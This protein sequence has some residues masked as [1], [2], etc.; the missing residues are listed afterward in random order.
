MLCVQV[1]N[2]TGVSTL[3]LDT[4]STPS[5]CAYEVLTPAEIDNLSTVSVTDFATLYQ[6]YFGFDADLFSLILVSCL[7]A[8]AMGHTIG[9]VWKGMAKTF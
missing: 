6:K 9:A 8:Y 3:V 2:V 1:Q 7:T 5:S 4:S